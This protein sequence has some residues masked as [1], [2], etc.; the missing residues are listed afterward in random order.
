MKQLY[1]TSPL[2]D[3]V[4]LGL[5]FTPVLIGRIGPFRPLVRR[6]AALNGHLTVAEDV[7]LA[8]PS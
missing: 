5:R 3:R 6:P 8:R 4:L 1:G 2:G 7:L